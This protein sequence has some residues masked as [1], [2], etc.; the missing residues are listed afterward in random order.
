MLVNENGPHVIV[1]P[2]SES[3]PIDIPM[4][5]HLAHDEQEEQYEFCMELTNDKDT[6]PP[7]REWFLDHDEKGRFPG[8]DL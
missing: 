7:M 6:S 2:H 8:L 3:H 4:P 1:L 5:A